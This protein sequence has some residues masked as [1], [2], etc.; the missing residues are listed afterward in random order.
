MAPLTDSGA[1]RISM[2]M[3]T[4]G[5]SERRNN[6]RQLGNTEEHIVPVPPLSINLFI[7]A[8]VSVRWLLS[9][10]NHSRKNKDGVECVQTFWDRSMKWRV[11]VFAAGFKARLTGD[12]RCSQSS[13]LVV[14]EPVFMY[15]ILNYSLDIKLG[16]T[17]ADL[18]WWSAFGVCRV[19]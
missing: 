18:V 9:P 8:A 7:S 12:D 15:L 14:G 11:G 1:P 16:V 19:F 6:P 13:C 4:S 5:K 2:T 17:G 10:P 3:W